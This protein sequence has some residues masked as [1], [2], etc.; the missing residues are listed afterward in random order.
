[1]FEVTG[2]GPMKGVI[3]TINATK[4]QG[5]IRGE[6]GRVR[7]FR[8]AGMVLWGDFLDLHPGCSVSFDEEA[9]RAMNVEL[10]P[11]VAASVNDG[12][13]SERRPR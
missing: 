4:M 1:M 5:T 7:A 8:R 10:A 9:G 2:S 6:D 3:V 11:F 12:K 13:R